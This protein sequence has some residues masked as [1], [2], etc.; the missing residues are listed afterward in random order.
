MD[1]AYCDGFTREDPLD[2][3]DFETE[4]G[5]GE[6]EILDQ[7]DLFVSGTYWA[8]ILSNVEGEEDV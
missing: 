8:N 4:F 2:D 3:P 7:P 6:V 5:T 1:A